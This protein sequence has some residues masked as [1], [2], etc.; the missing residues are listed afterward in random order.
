MTYDTIT[1]PSIS[2]VLDGG[3]GRILY[4][5][6]THKEVSYIWVG[7]ILQGKYFRSI[8]LPLTY[9]SRITNVLF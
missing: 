3:A 6:G 1:F 4:L 9:L 5:R 8:L 7:I 2:T